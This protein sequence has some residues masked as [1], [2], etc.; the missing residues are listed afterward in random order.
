MANVCKV[1]KVTQKKQQVGV[2]VFVDSQLKVKELGDLL[3]TTSTDKLQFELISS[4]GMKVFPGGGLVAPDSDFW[5][6]RYYGQEIT[7][8]DVHK[9]LENIE[10]CGLSWVKLESLYD[11]DGVRGFSL[12][13]G[14]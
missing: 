13:Q 12:C 3:A 6:I 1:C 8:G 5:R 7:H 10:K 14:E 9:L 4:R 11:Y 2:D